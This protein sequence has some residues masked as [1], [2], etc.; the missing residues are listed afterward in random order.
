MKL[1]SSLAE[2]IF[3]DMNEKEKFFI[4]RTN[5]H[6]ALVQANI[7]KVVKNLN[8]VFP[9]YLISDVTILVFRNTLLLQALKHDLSKFEEPER[10]PYIEMTW[11]KRFDKTNKDKNKLVEQSFIEATQH[12]VLTNKHHP[13]Y[14]DQKNAK[15]DPNNRDKLLKCI[16]ASEMPNN[17]VVEMVCDW[18]A[19]S[20]ELK[21]NTAREWFNKN[22]NVRWKFSDAQEKLILKTLDVLEME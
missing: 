22:K 13:E 16:D 10:T 19:M 8:K 15:I 4:D 17:Y 20:Q 9:D 3:K 14:W 21:T 5:K 1:L 7:Q 11:V 12:H 18:F 2:E 6:I